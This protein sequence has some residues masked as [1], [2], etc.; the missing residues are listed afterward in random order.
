MEGV[1]VV[2]QENPDIADTLRLRDVT[3]AII[4]VFLYMGRTL[5]SVWVTVKVGMYNY[6]FNTY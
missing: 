4:F 5:V 2:G 6:Y 3:M 1:R